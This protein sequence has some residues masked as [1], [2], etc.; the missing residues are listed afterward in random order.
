MRP[1][2]SSANP[3][4]EALWPVVRRLGT[5]MLD[6]V[7]PPRCL[8]CGDLVETAS[9]LCATCWPKVR[10]ITEPLCAACGIPFEFDV[11]ADT[12]CG[13]CA[14][15][16]RRPIGRVRAAI[17]YDDGSKRFI[18][19]FKNGDRTDAARLF[20]PWMAQAG[21]DLLRDADLLV[22][23][24][25]HWTRLFARRYNQAALLAQA[26][27]RLVGTPVAPDLLVRRKR[28]SRLGKSGGRARA[29]IVRGAIIAPERRRPMIAGRRIV[30]IDDVFTT[31][32]TSKACAAVLVERG[33]ATIDVLTLAR[34]VRP[35]VAGSPRPSA[36]KRASPELDEEPHA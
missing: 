7:L 31:G 28:T 32:S 16:D 22:P 5:G 10:F 29:D 9:A 3:L 8:T 14:A 20:A 36:L 23:V 35:I 6:A 26:V 30:L 4:P 15:T 24:P 19:A 34:V 17:A 27:G 1:R 2:V 12:V 33:A 25:L 11:G 18:L 13:A 21:R